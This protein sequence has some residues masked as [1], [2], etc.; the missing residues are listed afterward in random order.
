MRKEMKRILWAVG[1]LAVITVSGYEAWRI[2]PGKAKLIIWACVGIIL[3]TWTV[4]VAIWRFKQ[5]RVQC[6]PDPPKHN[7][8]GVGA[9]KLYDSRSLTLMLEEMQDQL[10]RVSGI[11]QKPITDAQ[12]AIQGQRTYSSEASLDASFAAGRGTASAGPDKGG[13][14]KPKETPKTTPST[15]KEG[16]SSGGSDSAPAPGTFA[17]RSADVL[18]DQVNLTYEILNLRLVLERALSDRLFGTNQARLQAVIG[19]PISVNT[20]EYASGCAAFFEVTVKA[21]GAPPSVVALLPQEET[22]NV[23]TSR[24]RSGGFGVSAPAKIASLALKSRALSDQAFLER[25]ADTIAFLGESA[26]DLTGGLIPQVTFGWQL[27]PTAGNRSVTAGLRQIFAV[28]AL[29]QKD[30]LPQDQIALEIS[31]RTYWRRFNAK[32]STS[33]DRLNWKAWFSNRPVEVK[34]SWLPAMAVTSTLAVE[35]NLSPRITGVNW[36][37]VGSNRAVVVVSGANF[38]PGTAVALGDQ[39]YRS[40]DDGLILKSEKT[41]QLSVPLTALMNDA[42]LNGRYGASILLEQ[43][44]SLAKLSAPSVELS[45]RRTSDVLQLRLVF[46]VADPAQTFDWPS[47]AKLPDPLLQVNDQILNTTLVFYPIRDAQQKCTGVGCL[48]LL[49]AELVPSN[50]CS[51]VLKFPFLGPDWIFKKLLDLPLARQLTLT[52]IH[53]DTN[54]G[55][56]L[57]G[58]V[59]S[60]KWKVHLDKDYAVGDGS[61]DLLGKELLRL[62]VL[63]ALLDKFDTLVVLPPNGPVLALPVPVIT[64]PTPMFDSTATPV[65][66]AKATTDTLVSIRGAHLEQISKVTCD[67]KD[68]TFAASNGGQLLK[69]ELKAEFASV[70]K[71]YELVLLDHAGRRYL[72]E[73]LVTT[74]PVP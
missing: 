60:D 58:D 11:S 33:S 65:T 47:F 67:A 56:L 19:F 68:L 73:L 69:I 54:A 45:D 16:A 9:P 52:R 48:A 25:Q 46:S 36:Y 51:V 53:Q 12:G 63:P 64:T 32:T 44:S 71:E 35:S 8:I 7:G 3:L 38:F 74:A 50:N 37:M 49:P 26:Q 57:W 40:S 61:L 59:F 2:W 18:S 27:R 13:D 55:L 30:E 39:T 29:P 42:V 5:R 72:I 66:V 4:M 22:S 10:R 15:P 6:W 62:T 21:A 43:R 17:E 31:T 1:P 14:A 41:L 70:N 28:L 34:Q 20:P 23:S 24:H